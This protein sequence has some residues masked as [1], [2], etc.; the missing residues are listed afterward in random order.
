MED[1]HVRCIF[2]KNERERGRVGCQ[3]M[4]YNSLRP[5]LLQF[6]NHIWPLTRALWWWVV[7]LRWSAFPD[8]FCHFLARFSFAHESKNS[9]KHYRKFNLKREFDLYGLDFP[10]FT[11]ELRRR[12]WEKFNNTIVKGCMGEGILHQGLLKKKMRRKCGGHMWGGRK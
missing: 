1:T 4:H 11:R 10:F 5:W 2:K 6:E 9:L 7:K 3:E 12:G 8:T